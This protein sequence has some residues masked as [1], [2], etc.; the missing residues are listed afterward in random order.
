MTQCHQG[1]LKLNV[2]GNNSPQSTIEPGSCTT[3]C[4]AYLTEGACNVGTEDYTLVG[5]AKSS[6][7]PGVPATNTDPQ[8]PTNY[9]TSQRP[10]ID[11][12]TGR[13]YPPTRTLALQPSI[14]VN[15]TV[16]GVVRVKG[17]CKWRSGPKCTWASDTCTGGGNCAGIPDQ[18]TCVLTSI[19]TG[20][21][22]ENCSAIF[23]NENNVCDNREG[24]KWDSRLNKCKQMCKTIKYQDDCS[25]YHGCQW[26]AAAGICT[27]KLDPDCTE[28]PVNGVCRD[29][30]C[31]ADYP[32]NPGP[33]PG[34]RTTAAGVI[35][36][37]KPKSSERRYYHNTQQQQWWDECALA[38]E[39]WGEYTRDWPPPSGTACPDTD[40]SIPP[41]GQVPYSWFRGMQTPQIADFPDGDSGYGSFRTPFMTNY[42]DELDF[43]IPPSTLFGRAKSDARHMTGQH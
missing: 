10:G 33:A 13:A 20:K 18:D 42:R 8:N 9:Y 21:C 26:N 29:Y 37:C 6:S 23:S 35:T 36:S 14:M 38:D 5:E 22:H 1:W 27:D 16:N 19:N 32:L 30:R 2:M 34:D 41:K 31:T 25:V 40:Q 28:G 43:L 3:G 11:P 7:D 24:C 4:N 17:R 15:E 39:N 12:N